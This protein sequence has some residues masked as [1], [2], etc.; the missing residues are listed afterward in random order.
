MSNWRDDFDEFIRVLTQRMEDG[1]WTYGDKSLNQPIPKTLGELEQELIDIP[2]WSYIAW[3]RIRRIRS[4]METTFKNSETAK[5][6]SSTS[7]DDPSE[8]RSSSSPPGDDA[9]SSSARPHKNK[10]V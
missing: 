3:R 4:L 1:Y 5:P 8:T 6:S 2:G 9:S 10:S 7:P